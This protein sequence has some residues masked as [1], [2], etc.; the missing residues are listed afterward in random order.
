VLNSTQLEA[1]LDEWG[2]EEGTVKSELSWKSVAV[3]ALLVLAGVTCSL[4]GD[5]TLGASLVGGALGFLA[6]GFG[7]RRDTPPGTPETI[8]PEQSS[9]T[10]G[11]IPPLTTL[12]FLSVSALWALMFVR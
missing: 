11:K 3:I 10:V 2:G 1:L 12:M 9:K 6:Q 4:L 5:K 8:L 7:Y